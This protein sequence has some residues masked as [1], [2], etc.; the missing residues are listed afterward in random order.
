MADSFFLI[1]IRLY[2]AHLCGDILTYLPQLAGKK[3]V[4]DPQSKIRAIALHCL[5]HAAWVWV[6]SWGWSAYSRLLAAIYIVGLHFLIDFSRG[7]LENALIGTANLK[8]LKR[9]QVWLWLR[10]KGDAMTN[11]FM[12]KYLN[13]WICINLADQTLHFL[14]VLLVTLLLHMD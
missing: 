7:Y 14:T 4:A 2:A 9:R 10:R 13:K 3:R 12:S 8:I 5:I 6:W 1:F 11:N